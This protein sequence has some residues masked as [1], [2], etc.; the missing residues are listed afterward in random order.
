M[1]NSYENFEIYCRTVDLTPGSSFRSPTKP[2]SI[3]GNDNF[4]VRMMVETIWFMSV[5]AI[6]SRMS[7]IALGGVGGVRFFNLDK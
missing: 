4:Q 1:Q 2:V 7:L 3:F 5:P 6:L